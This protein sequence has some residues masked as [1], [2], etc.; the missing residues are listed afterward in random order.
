VPL[1]NYVIAPGGSFVAGGHFIDAQSVQIGGALTARAGGINIRADSVNL[2]GN[3]AATSDIEIRAPIIV[4]S[5]S[6]ITAGSRTAPA[7][8]IFEATDLFVDAGTGAANQWT[9]HGGIQMLSLP[10]TS[11]L[12][13]T[14][15]RVPLANY[16][17]ALIR[18]PAN[19]FGPSSGGFANNLALGIL[20]L[21]GGTASLHRF[22]SVEDS[23]AI[24]IN[25]L[26]LN[27]VNPATSIEIEPGMTVYFADTDANPTDLDGLH[28]GRLRFVPGFAGP[29]NS[30]NVVYPS[31]EVYT[32][33]TALVRS[34]V[35]DSDGDGIVNALDSTPVIVGDRI[36]LKIACSRGTATRRTVISWMAPANSTSIVEYKD[37]LQAAW[38]ALPA[39]QNPGAA[40]RLSISEDLPTAGAGQRFYRVRTE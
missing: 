40:Q 25:R 2:S 4:A 16:G 15:V 12:L 34:T 38:Q 20:D 7:S 22:E 11:D 24:Y 30:T 33:N 13:G 27:G 19:D 17:E 32:L 8:L 5:N 37:S 31:G 36:D 6:F 10:G 26:N 21:S 23:G 39:V 28:G 1:E 18:W 9:A 35:L 14:T 3:L 29:L